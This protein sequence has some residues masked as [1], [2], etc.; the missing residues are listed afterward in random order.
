MNSE[1]HHLDTG[2]SQFV[3]G[4]PVSSSLVLGL[5]VTV[6]LLSVDMD[7]GAPSSVHNA[8]TAGDPSTAPSLQPGFTFLGTSSIL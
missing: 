8:C 2:G 1:L 3:V 5:Q 7:S 4:P 6:S